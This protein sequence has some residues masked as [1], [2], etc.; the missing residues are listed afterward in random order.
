MI[1]ST[2]KGVFFMGNF[3]ANNAVTKSTKYVESWHTCACIPSLNTRSTNS[4]FRAMLVNFILEP[5]GTIQ[6]GKD[7][8]E[9]AIKPK[10]VKR[11]R[12]KKQVENESAVP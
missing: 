1:K 9:K 3:I 12:K 8:R 4:I 10:N 6:Y 11:K 2:E 5:I 7:L